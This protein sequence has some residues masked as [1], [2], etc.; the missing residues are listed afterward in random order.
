MPYREYLEGV[1]IELAN[2]T[3]LVGFNLKYDLHW[4]RRYGIQY[5]GKVFDVQIAFFI[6]TGQQHPYPSL[7][8]VAD[9]YGVEKKLDVVKEEYWNKG[10]DTDEVPRRIL[11]DYLGQDLKTT[12][13]CY[14]KVQEDLKKQSKEMQK[15]ISIA[16]QDLLV[17]QEMEWNGMLIDRE[18]SI[19]KGDALVERIKVI[20]ESLRRW[21][22]ADWLNP[23]SGDHLSAILY[24]GTINVP[25][26]E[27]YRFVYKDGRE[28]WKERNSVMPISPPRQLEPLKG[29]A[30]AKEGFWSTDIGTLTTLRGKANRHMKQVIDLLLERSKIEKKR[31]T[32]FHGYPKK[33][34]LWNWKDNVIHSNLNQCVVI[35]GRLSSSKPNLQNVE[36]EVKEIFVSRY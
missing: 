11:E 14:Q 15:T 3:T 33:L 20:D 31:S 25:Y 21:F 26:R 23:N 8:Q 34:D 6:L 9:Y 22:S 12:F 2:T 13:L 19:R 28:V 35:T 27:S 4:L 29:T 18:K 36:E 16:M 5:S 24:G 30:L 1:K 32:Y 7:D 17:L 10:L